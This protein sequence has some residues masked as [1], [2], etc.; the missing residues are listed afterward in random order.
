M[1]R[2]GTE[3]ATID[4]LQLVTEKQS[5]TNSNWTLEAVTQGENQN[6]ADWGSLILRGN[7]L[8]RRLERGGIR[9]THLKI[10]V[11]KFNPE[12]GEGQTPNL[13]W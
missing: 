1:K 8:T 7:S 4:C 11:E 6:E 13:T 2:K 10:L 3:N 12:K 5:K 9:D